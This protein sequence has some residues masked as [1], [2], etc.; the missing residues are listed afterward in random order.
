MIILT[1]KVN[2]QG[3]DTISPNYQKENQISLD[4]VHYGPF[5]PGEKEEGLLGHVKGKQILEI[6]CG[7]GQNSIAL[8]KWG[9]IVT[10]VDQSKEQLRYAKVLAN[11]ENVDVQFLLGNVEN[12][13]KLKNSTFDTIVSSHA[14]N[15][16]EKLDDVFRECNRLLKPNGKFVICL[17]HPV[18]H[19]VWE[20]LEEDN[21][22]LLKKSNYFERNIAW[23]W[24]FPDGTKAPFESRLWTF[25]DIINGLIEN[26]FLITRIR[27][28]RGY[29]TNNLSS[30]ELSLIPYQWDLEKAQK[31]I[32]LNQK[33]PY[34][35]IVVAIKKKL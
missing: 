22:D 27:E 35:L 8:A 26:G 16:V 2:Q 11:Q 31:F 21:F 24:D 17:S 6:G 34:S 10:G 29:N 20:S 4:D 28:P 15:Y 3:W 5:A 30:E 9:A 13:S 7:G 23:D 32:L 12:L 19:Y 1:N 18:S 33:F 25:E 14:L